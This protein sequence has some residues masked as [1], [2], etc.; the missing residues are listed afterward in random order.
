MNLC[1]SG[2]TFIVDFECMEKDQN[3]CSKYHVCL[4][5][6]FCSI[7]GVVTEKLIYR[8]MPLMMWHCN[9]CYTLHCINDIVQRLTAMPHHLVNDLGNEFGTHRI[10]LSKFKVF[11][12]LF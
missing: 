5:V 11:D 7:E 2:F 1:A 6:T 4:G 10:N 3:W 9:K 12:D 8:Q